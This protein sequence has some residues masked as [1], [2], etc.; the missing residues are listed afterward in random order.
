MS[1]SNRFVNNKNHYYENI[2][3]IHELNN[4]NVAQKQCLKIVLIGRWTKPASYPINTNT[5][6]VLNARIQACRREEIPMRAVFT[7]T[8]CQQDRFRFMH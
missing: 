4:D 8:L 7:E 6:C 1:H 5:I 3:H 2:Y